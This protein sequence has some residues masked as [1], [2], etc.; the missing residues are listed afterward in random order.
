M[1]ILPYNK[2]R[3]LEAGSTL[4]KTGNVQAL[5]DN[6]VCSTYYNN[7]DLVETDQFMCFQNTGVASCPPVSRVINVRIRK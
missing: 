5:A 2:L 1:I 3:Y 6:S 4:K 7:D